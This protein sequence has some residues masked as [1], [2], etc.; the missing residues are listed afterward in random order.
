MVVHEVFTLMSSP[1]PTTNSETTN[2][3]FHFSHIFWLISS[4]TI[5]VIVL[6]ILNLKHNLIFFNSLVKVQDSQFRSF[7]IRYWI[8]W[9]TVKV[10]IFLKMF[11]LIFISLS[12]S[13]TQFYESRISLFTFWLFFP[14]KSFKLIS[15]YTPKILWI[16]NFNF[17]NLRCCKVF[18]FFFI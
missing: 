2:P 14:D 6:S 13:N 4:S 9:V 15:K 3:S 5:L 11:A 16:P 18:F 12:A 17:P 10:F 1:D 7:G 8:R